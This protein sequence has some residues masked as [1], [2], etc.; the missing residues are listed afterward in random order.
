MSQL[1]LILVTELT[2]KVGEK[3]GRRRGR[4]EEEQIAYDSTGLYS[5]E[6]TSRRVCRNQGLLLAYK[7]KYL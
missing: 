1:L 5:E 6:G 7:L 2:D 4:Q 3:S